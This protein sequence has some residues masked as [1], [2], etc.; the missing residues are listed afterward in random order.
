MIAKTP[1]TQPRRKMGSFRLG[2]ALLSRT[3]AT[4]APPWPSS[5]S[6]HRRRKLVACVT[7]KDSSVTPIRGKEPPLAPIGAAAAAP[8]PRSPP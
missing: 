5:R 8:H 1:W 4:G 2:S 3:T 6:R 7:L